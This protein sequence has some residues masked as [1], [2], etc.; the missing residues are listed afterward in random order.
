MT[1][2][3]ERPGVVKKAL[4]EMSDALLLDT[5]RRRQRSLNDLEKEVR[6]RGLPE[7]LLS[8]S[9]VARI[10]QISEPTL[11]RLIKSGEIKSVRIGWQH[12]ISQKEIRRILHLDKEETS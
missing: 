3:Q 1:Q 4:M 5:I 6:R 2:E 10:L 9:T 8:I 12:R 11:R 7:A